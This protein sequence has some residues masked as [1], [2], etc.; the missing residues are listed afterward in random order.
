MADPAVAARLAAPAG[1]ADAPLRVLPGGARTPPRP[2]P[3]LEVPS[4]D[5]KAA[6]RLEHELGISHVLAQALV[7]RG[8]GDPDVARAFLEAR[9]SHPPQAFAGI[10]QA[11]ELIHRHVEAGSRITV[12]GDYD[13][14]G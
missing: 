9:E 3:R 11:V 5:L 10:A 6:L 8:A 12:H 4:Y 14:D 2:R 1:P 13:V 7:R